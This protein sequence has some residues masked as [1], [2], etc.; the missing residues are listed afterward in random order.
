MIR[1]QLLSLR[2]LPEKLENDKITLF[3]LKLSTD[4]QYK[5]HT[6]SWKSNSVSQ[7]SNMLSPT[8]A[9]KN[10]KRQVALF[11]IFLFQ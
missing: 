1:D 7:L 4:I 5:G 9:S 8:P 6:K 3:L 10:K 2:I 11:C